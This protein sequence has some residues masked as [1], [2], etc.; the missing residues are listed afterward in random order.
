MGKKSKNRLSVIY[1]NPNETDAYARFHS[2]LFSF[3]WF[4]FRAVMIG[5]E[6]DRPFVFVFMHAA[7]RK[8]S[9]FIRGSI[10]IV[11]IYSFVHRLI[12]DGEEIDLLFKKV[13]VCSRPPVTPVF[14]VATDRLVKRKG[15]LGEVA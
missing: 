7:E 6:I 12:Y 15:Y 3:V 10:I 11:I 13:L 9:R 1:S 2:K 4:F 14:D 8:I 5:S